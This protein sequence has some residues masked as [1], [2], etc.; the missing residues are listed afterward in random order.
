[1]FKFFRVAALCFATA[2]SACTSIPVSSLYRLSRIDFLTTDLSRFRFA[3]TVP[4]SL[5]PQL[6]GVQMDLAYTQGDKPEEKRVVHLE[7][8]TAAAD[9]VGLPPA[10][11][12]SQIFVFK[13]PTREV[14]TLN[15]IR[16]DAIL[17][18]AR[19]QKGSLSMGIAAKEFCTLG[20]VP[21]TALLITTYVL[22]SE[23]SEY[24]MLTRNAD[25]RSDKTISE[26]LD[27]LMPCD[28]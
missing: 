8:S 22:S 11:E 17:A 1:M 3:I 2:V 24:V 18:K 19:Q 16:S 12:G 4:N 20:A 15:K 10:Q 9:F 25:L 27:H 21:K 23:N 26:S 5:R 28:K 13:L 14:A 6:G 7:Q